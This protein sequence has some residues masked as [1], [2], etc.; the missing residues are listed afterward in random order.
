MMDFICCYC[1]DPATV[2]DHFVPVS[3]G[4]TDNRDNLWPSCEPCNSSKRAYLL[5]EWRATLAFRS[6]YPPSCG[7]G[8]KKALELEALGAD[9]HIPPPETVTFYFEDHYIDTPAHNY[10][11]VSRSQ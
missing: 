3:R 7:I 10:A 4:G 5:E 6:K 1:G 11:G 9:F 8:L 2:L